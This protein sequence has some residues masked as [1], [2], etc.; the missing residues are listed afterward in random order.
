MFAATACGR[1]TILKCGFPAGLLTDPALSDEWLESSAALELLPKRGIF[2][3]KKSNGEVLIIA[4][5]RRYMG[6]AILAAMGVRAGGA[7]L[8]RLVYPA[9]AADNPSLT[10]PW[11]ICSPAEDSGSGVFTTASLPEIK[12]S[13]LSADSVVIGPGLDRDPETT[14]FLEKLLPELRR[15]VFDADGL[16]HLAGLFGK[17]SVDLPPYSI[18]TP[19]PGELRTLLGE[20]FTEQDI[21]KFSA[22]HRTVLTAK[23]WQTKVYSPEGNTRL[24]TGGSPALATAGT[25]DVLAGLSA[26]LL[27]RGLNPF[28]AA[29][30]AGYLHASAGSCLA[31]ERGEDGLDPVNLANTV[32]LMRDLLKNTPAGAPPPER[33]L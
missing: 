31:S 16:W 8:I 20:K 29:S 5:S 28:D 1:I 15:A 4:G 7:G 2:S 9:G 23:D 21:V 14:A 27:A 11:L 32:P 6:A 26:S 30:L 12:K 17:R 3:H 24:I 19:H 13:A 18:L 33:T 10:Y 22:S 25:G